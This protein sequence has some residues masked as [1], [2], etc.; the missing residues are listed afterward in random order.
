LIAA[1]SIV[2]TIE[3]HADRRP[4]A[5]QAALPTY[6]DSPERTLGTWKNWKRVCQWIRDNTPA[7]AVFITPARQQTFKW[8][9]GRHE[10]VAWKDIPQDAAS[11]IDWRTRVAE[12]YDIQHQFPAGL[13]QYT[14]EQLAGFAQKYSATHLLVP[15]YQVDLLP[16]ATKLK[17]IYPSDPSEKVT[18]AVFE[19][20]R[21]RLSDES[22]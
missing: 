22:K 16:G 4:P 7:D 3:N 12:L 21:D 15:Q 11:I 2:I 17:Q 13:L 14:D 5:D 1:A 10:V 19:L 18:Y 6:E 9:A 8:Y 20:N